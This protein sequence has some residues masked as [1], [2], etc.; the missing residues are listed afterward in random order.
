M[1]TLHFC[2]QNGE[3]PGSETQDIDNVNFGNVDEP[4]I[5]AI[6]H[7]LRRGTPSFSKY[8]R[9]L[10]TEVWDTISNMKF[11]KSAGDYKTG[12]SLK[13]GANKEYA[14]PSQTDTGDSAIPITEGTALS[15]QSAEGE[16]EII[17][18]ETG[19]SGYTKYIRLQL[20]STTSTPTGNAN[21]KTLVFQ[22]DEI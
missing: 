10:F 4:N 7:Q 3:S 1:A 16:S 9:V 2:E 17:Y 15:I 5:V 21:Q 6:S 18:G 8:I 11:W 20:H 22:W 12:E 19:V 13:A 14:T